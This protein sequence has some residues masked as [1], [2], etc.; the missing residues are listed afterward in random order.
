MSKNQDTAED[1]VQTAMVRTLE[2]WQSINNRTP[3]GYLMAACRNAWIDRLRLWETKITCQM[4]DECYALAA[5]SY[6]PNIAERLEAERRLN[7]ID[8]ALKFA[9]PLLAHGYS[10]GEAGEAVG[11]TSSALKSPVMRN[12]PHRGFEQGSLKVLGAGGGLKP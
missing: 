9:L 3:K 7:L 2:N 11:L 6:E 8:P 12:I 4:S 5:D 1:L 10:Y